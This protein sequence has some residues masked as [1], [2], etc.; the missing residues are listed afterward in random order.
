MISREVIATRLAPSFLALGPDFSDCHDEVN[1]EDQNEET[2]GGFASGGL[3]VHEL[4][5]VQDC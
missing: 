4:R 2:R 5:G 3:H 1:E